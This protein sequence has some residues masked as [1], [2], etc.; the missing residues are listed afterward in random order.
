MYTIGLGPGGPVQSRS[1]WASEYASWIKWAE[2]TG[3]VEEQ[4]VGTLNGAPWRC[5]FVV[6]QQVLT[7][8]RMMWDRNNKLV[9]WL[10]AANAMRF[11]DLKQ[12]VTTIG[13]VA[14]VPTFDITMD[15]IAASQW[16]G[17]TLVPSPAHSTVRLIRNPKTGK[18]EVVKADLHLPTIKLDE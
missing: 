5:P 18:I 17:V 13:G 1:T 6:E 2:R 7:D 16:P 9:V 12:S 10:A 8:Y 4:T 11:I 3:I 15:V 14:N